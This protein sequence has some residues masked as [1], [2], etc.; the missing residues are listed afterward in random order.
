M[1]H[2]EI[3]SLAH[4][5]TLESESLEVESRNLHFIQVFQT[6]VSEPNLK[7]TCLEQRNRM[8]NTPGIS[9]D[10]GFNLCTILDRCHSQ[11]AESCFI[12]FPFLPTTGCADHYRSEVS[13]PG[14]KVALP[15]SIACCTDWAAFLGHS[16]GT[17]R[18]HLEPGHGSAVPTE[19]GDRHL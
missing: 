19:A 1:E 14:W 2:W 16:W 10:K 7:M 13:R 8:I 5:T 15:A 11:W 9:S 17:L 4:S 3:N 12:G 6:M 18:V